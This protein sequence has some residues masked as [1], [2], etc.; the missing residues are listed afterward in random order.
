MILQFLGNGLVNGCLIALVALG[1]SLVYNTTRIFHIAYA[2]IYLWAGYMLYFFLEYL[3]WPLAASFLMAILTAGALS[4]ACEKLIYAPLAKRG[5]SS[6]SLMISSV[7]VLILL[8]SLAE[9]LF[10]SAARYVDME[11]PGSALEF[12]IY[13]PGFKVVSLLVSIVIL[14]LFFITLKYSPMG[15]RVRAL[16]DNELLSGVFGLNTARL[17]AYLFILSGALAALASGLSILDVGINPHLGIP[18]FINA[19]VALVI[20]G[21]GRFDGPVLGGILLG[22]L[23]AMTEYFFD[24]RWVMMVTFILL[25]VFLIVRPQGLIPSR[26]RA[27]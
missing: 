11:L 13:I 19:F 22:L 12:G 10:G 4:L 3:H 6:N 9:L 23:Q 25:F 21:I 16:R 24:S 18:L 7:G 5:R 1:F 27:F 2:G 17:K 14:I 26:L 15:I 20:G 8:V